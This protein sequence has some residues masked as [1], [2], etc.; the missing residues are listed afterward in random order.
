MNPVALDRAARLADFARSGEESRPRLR[1]QCGSLALEAYFDAI[2]HSVLLTV[3]YERVQ[4]K[5]RVSEWP[6]NR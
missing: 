2:W 3:G 6:K 4:A 5:P 1:R